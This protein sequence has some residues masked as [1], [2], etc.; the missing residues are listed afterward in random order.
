[1]CVRQ[2]DGQ[3]LT[4]PDGPGTRT[5][6]RQE[7]SKAPKASPAGIILHDR[8]RPRHTGVRWISADEGKRATREPVRQGELTRE[9]LIKEQS[10]GSSSP[11]SHWRSWRAPCLETDPS[12]ALGGATGTRAPSPLPCQAWLPGPRWPRAACVLGAIIVAR[13]GGDDDSDGTVT[14]AAE[15]SSRHAS[16]RRRPTTDDRQAGRQAASGREGVQF[17][18]LHRAVGRGRGTATWKS[19]RTGLRTGANSLD[20][21]LG[22]RPIAAAPYA[23]KSGGWKPSIQGHLN[24]DLGPSLGDVPPQDTPISHRNGIQ[25]PWHP[26]HHGLVTGGETQQNRWAPRAQHEPS[27]ISP[28]PPPPPPEQPDSAILWFFPSPSLPPLIR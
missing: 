24:G 17:T 1:M 4:L 19:G 12:P 7:G 9:G 18:Q 28:A 20:V 16:T 22:S 8:A 13:A 21:M 10:V 11:A 14:A 6:S 26:R 5:G 15:Q 2:G 25:D 27:S 23:G 3:T